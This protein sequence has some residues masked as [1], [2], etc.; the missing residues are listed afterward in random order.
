MCAFLKLQNVHAFCRVLT[1]LSQKEE[2]VSKGLPFK[3]IFYHFTYIYLYNN[4]NQKQIL[5]TLQRF[6]TKTAVKKNPVNC[7]LSKRE[8]K[9][10]FFLGKIENL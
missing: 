4:R 1:S 7:N 9:L 3:R 6:S 5:Q 8:V 10:D 2:N